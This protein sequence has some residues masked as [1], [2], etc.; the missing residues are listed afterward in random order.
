M[1]EDS[2]YREEFNKTYLPC[3]TEYFSQEKMETKIES[4]KYLLE[5]LKK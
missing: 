3:F 2:K 4:Y 5:E 1:A